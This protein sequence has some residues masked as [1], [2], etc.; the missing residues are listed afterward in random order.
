MR[1]RLRRPSSRWRG[2]F[3]GTSTTSS[4]T[5]RR[6][7]A[8]PSA[9]SRLPRVSSAG[10]AGTIYT[11]TARTTRRTT[12]HR[13]GWAAILRR[14]SGRGGVTSD[15]LPPTPPPIITTPFP[16]NVH[17]SPPNCALFHLYCT[18]IRGPLASHCI[19]VDEEDD[20]YGLGWCSAKYTITNKPLQRRVVLLNTITNRPLV[21]TDSLTGAQ[22][23]VV[24]VMLVT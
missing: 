15:L 8:A 14:R 22:V 17:F 9:G 4:C 2:T 3:R 10:P 7:H 12:A 11:F 24:G 5:T 21:R 18:N 6:G 16:L 13:S 20:A 1:R 19:L 23:G